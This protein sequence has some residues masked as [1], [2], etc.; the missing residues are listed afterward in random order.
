LAK[1]QFHFDPMHLQDPNGEA[2]KTFR[3]LSK[4]PEIGITAA[5]IVAPSLPEARHLAASL[6]RLPQAAGT[7]TIDM[8]VPADQDAK[9]PVI[10][11]AAKQL[12]PAL[13]SPAQPAPTDAQNVE[14]IRAAAG[15]VQ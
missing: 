5:E 7:R 6:A 10:E 12:G 9:I 13:Q 8:L 4:S 15:A 14:A 2:V 3:E 1:M 11:A